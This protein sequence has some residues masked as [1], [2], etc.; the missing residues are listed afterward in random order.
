MSALIWILLGIVYVGCRVYF[1]MATFRNGHYVLLACKSPGF[2]TALCRR[3][4]R[5]VSLV[6]GDR[7]VISGPERG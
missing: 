6:L 3:G 1:G 7:L 2:V 5:P 4:R